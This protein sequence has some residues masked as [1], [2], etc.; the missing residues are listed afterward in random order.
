MAQ[1]HE[2]SARALAGEI[3]NGKVSAREATDYF[4]AR[5]EKH[6]PPLNAVIV[7]RFEAARKEAITADERQA[8]GEA[9]GALHGVPMTIKESFEIAGTTCEIGVPDYKGYMSTQDSYVVNRLKAAGAIMLGKTNVPAFLA[10]VQSFNALYGTT[11]NPW[12]LARTPGGSS[13]G[14]AAALAAMLTPLEYGSDIAGSIRVPAHFC[15]VF[16]HKPSHGIVPTRGH[17]PPHGGLGISDLAVVGPLARD[18]EDLQLA[19]DLTYGVLPPQ[20]AALNLRL[21]GARATRPQDIRIGIWPRD[22][23]CEVDDAISTR[24]EDMAQR[25]EQEGAEIRMIKPDFNLADYSKVYMQL[26]SAIT[27]AGFPTHVKQSLQKFLDDNPDTENLRI[28]QARG[29]LLTHAQWI[30]LNEQR[31]QLAQKWG[32]LFEQVDVLFCPISPSAAMVHMQEESAHKRRIMVNGAQRHY[33]DNFVWP[34]VATLCGLPATAVPIGLTETGLP[35]GMQIIA[36]AFEDNTGLAVAQM[37][38][39]LGIGFIPPPDYAD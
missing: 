5:I 28:W 25:L 12:D 8:N 22:P 30:V 26:L 11:N 29:A 39:R 31:L 27:G 17:V 20:N 23:F 6:N 1:L 10:D 19:L 4:I 38:S 2:L 15:G 35:I 16:G 24:I 14:S 34:G 13:G 18:V 33:F 9:L 3:A 37:L 21:Q 36:P 7:N 32:Q